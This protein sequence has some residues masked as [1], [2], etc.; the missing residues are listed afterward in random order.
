MQQL[1][2]RPP[3]SQHSTHCGYQDASRN[4]ILLPRGLPMEWLLRWRILPQLI[5]LQTDIRLPSPV[6]QTWPPRLRAQAT[7]TA[8]LLSVP[9]CNFSRG[10][11][12]LCIPAQTITHY[13]TL[14]SDFWAPPNHAPAHKKTTLTTINLYITTQNSAKLTFKLTLSHYRYQNFAILYGPIYQLVHTY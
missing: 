2:V 12:P 4:M 6:S 9:C 14:L 3:S 7:C 1:Y 10:S 5:Y 13:T 8:K 11:R